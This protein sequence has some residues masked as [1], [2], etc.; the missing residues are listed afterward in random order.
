MRLLGLIAGALL[1]GFIGYAIAMGTSIA[2]P[3]ADGGDWLT[4][5]AGAAGV[6]LTV[7]AA[8]L[9]ERYRSK[10][11]ERAGHARLREVLAEL[12]AAVA[13][14]RSI[15]EWSGSSGARGES[16]SRQRRLLNAIC[17]YHFVRGKVEISDLALWE[18]LAEADTAMD[19]HYRDL[20]QEHVQLGEAGDSEKAYAGNRRRVT[21]TAVR[22]AP[23]VAEAKAAAGRVV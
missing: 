21:E 2:I 23:Y 15:P 18:A 19:R 12:D 1:C 10:W 20:A 13:G 17:K 5:G 7:L 9:I 6:M 4:A 11:Q 14:V 22:L 8:V 16:L 3:S